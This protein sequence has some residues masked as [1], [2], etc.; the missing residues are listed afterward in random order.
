MLHFSNN[1]NNFSLFCNF[2]LENQSFFLENLRNCETGENALKITL[3]RDS[4]GKNQNCARQLTAMKNKKSRK[5]AKDQQNFRR[6]AK[7]KIAAT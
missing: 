3:A 4:R 6:S 1:L 2:F 7:M 5:S